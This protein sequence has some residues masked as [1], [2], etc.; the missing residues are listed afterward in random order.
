MKKYKI[1]A[2]L[3]IIILLFALTAC[4]AENTSD[5]QTGQA[6]LTPV[7]MC[8]DWTPNTN[9]TGLYVAV[10]KGY[11]AEHGLDVTIVQPAEDSAAAL[12]AAGKVDFAIEFQDTLAAAFAMDKPLGITAVAAILQHNTSGVLSRAGEGIDRP[13]G[14]AGKKYSTWNSPI[15]LA[16]L[17]YVVE[18]DGGD[19]SA[20]E[21]IPNTITDEPAALA[22]KQTDAVWV[23]YGWGGINATVEGVASDYFAFADIDKVFDYYTPVLITG[24]Q[25]IADN[26]ELV[27]AFVDAT[28]AGYEYAAANPQEAARILI[29]GDDTGSLKGSED[30][31]YTSQEWISQQYKADAAKWGLIDQERWDAFYAWLYDKDLIANK[32]PAGFGFSNDFLPQ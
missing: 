29:E 26:P 14:L 3:L 20:V 13:S 18:A 24:D 8:L 30:L 10:A 32:I 31:V 11:Y 25:L 9:H 15:E 16:M 5:N 17:Q 28:A 7:T 19:F 1:L 23:F 6:D 2:L 4:N 27:E 21:L 12:C 22:A